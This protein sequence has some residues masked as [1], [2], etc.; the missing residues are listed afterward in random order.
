MSLRSGAPRDKIL[1]ETITTDDFEKLYKLLHEYRD[2]FAENLSEL[3]RAKS[4]TAETPAQLYHLTD[5]WYA[6]QYPPDMIGLPWRISLTLR[7]RRK[8]C[9]VPGWWGATHSALKRHT[10]LPVPHWFSHPDRIKVGL[11][12]TAV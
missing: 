7:S 8:L 9:Q 1:T 4:T 6:K 11:P 10:H 5:R 2:C 3:G 12:A